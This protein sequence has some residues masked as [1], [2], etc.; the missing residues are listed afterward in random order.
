MDIA[1]LLVGLTL[2]VF[3]LY[4][5]GA[6]LL[7]GL[8]RRSS[9][10][11]FAGV[12][13]W[14]FTAVLVSFLL[15]GLTG[16]VLAEVGMF[17]AWLIVVLVALSSLALAL[18]VGESGLKPRALLSLLRPQRS[19]PQRE[20][21]RRTARLLR[22]GLLVC[23]VA[24]VGLFSRPAE[25]LRGALDSG[26]YIN[27]GVSLGRT[28]SIFQ[29]DIL[30]RQ[31]NNDTGEV[32]ELLQ[33]LS[34][35]RYALSN[36][37]MAGF[38]VLDKKAALVMPQ[39]YSLY[40]TWI[41]L[42]YT[43]FG[44]W[45]ALY[46]NSL[47]A[48]LG[49]LAVYFFARRAFNPAAA[50][51]GLALLIVCPVTIWFARYPVS[52][53]LEGLLAFAGCLSFLRMF[54]LS[55]PVASAENPTGATG[56]PAVP[57]LSIADG[58]ATWACF[59]GLLAGVSLG[60]LAL[61]RPDFIFFVAPLPLYFLYWRLT[62]RWQPAYTWLLGALAA[63]LAVYLVHLSIY[64][65]AYTLDLYHNTIL[66]LR[67]LW[68]PL[69]LAL[70]VGVLA[71]IAL[72]RLYPRLAPLWRRLEALAVRYRW[73][74]AGALILALTAYAIWHYAI[75]PWRPN[76]RFDSAG[77]PIPQQ[78]QTTLESY[79]GAPVDQGSR[80]NLL[81]VGWYLSPLGML[82]GIAGFMR[83]IWNRL[84]AATALF[85]GM[86]LILSFAFLEETYTDPHYIYTMRRYVPVILPALILGIAWSCQ[87]CWSRLRPRLVGRVVAGVA[88]LGL[89]VFFLY[90]SHTIIPHVEE[91]GAVAEFTSLAKVFKNPDKSVVLFSN[92]RDEPYV[93]STPLQFIF[94]VESFVLWRDYPNLNNAVVEGVVKRWQSQGYDVY[95]M[96]GANGGKLYF[97]D[98]A[99]TAVG[100]WQYLVPEFEQQYYQKPTNIYNAF[101]PWGIYKFEPTGQAP[102]GGA[103]QG[104]PSATVQAQ[105]QATASAATPMPTL[106]P[107]VVQIASTLPFSLTVGK[108]DYPWLVA[109]F[110][111][112]ESDDGGKTYWRWTGSQAILRV[113][114]PTQAGGK[115]YDSAAITLRLRPE[116]V[117]AGKA[118]SRTQPLT[119]TVTL[120]DTQIG[121]FLVQPGAGFTDYTVQAPP[122]TPKKERDPNT[123]LLH[124]YAPTWSGGSTAP[125]GDTR[126]L[127]VQIDGVEVRK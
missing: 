2:L 80:Y 16:F 26:V 44:V 24:A 95:V 32:N 29:R 20:A 10:H 108:M 98:M 102:A 27:A 118:P 101:L 12:D 83:W 110:N 64:G 31:L 127:G 9:R 21:D 91:G 72:D 17:K 53:E 71:L 18:T 123:A 100:S 36:L 58:R 115:T 85:L 55:K 47:L 30:M 68:G 75:D 81:R 67:R 37:R 1:K 120:D 57:P 62:R 99:M 112:Q 107:G 5:P 111:T 25:M 119:V 116:S 63:V 90:T 92:N 7:N 88:A 109:G 113:P 6:V 14:L 33:P 117:Q 86:F 50:L 103:P 19:F 23:I 4:A 48:L 59:W 124:I 54:Q 34:R 8:G 15:T 74:W 105:V 40:P 13:E 41:A 3:L 125:G 73:A 122:G 66:D 22:I 51:L 56:V 84:S 82:L 70:Y 49:V 87:W 38:Y 93:V 106:L 11:V 39:H 28:G 69:L 97:P 42:M 65:F 46:A 79:I 45:G 104:V 43:L 60:Q 126:A 114:M 96:M 35:D 76:I 61:A 78:V 77:N 94:G 52:E 121:K 89:G